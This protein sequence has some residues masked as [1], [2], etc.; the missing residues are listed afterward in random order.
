MGGPLF[1][2]PSLAGTPASVVKPSGEGPW[3]VL[4]F[5]NGVVTEGRKL[6]E[7]RRVA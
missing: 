2:E 5:V 1:T 3:P 4:F 7:V 6:P